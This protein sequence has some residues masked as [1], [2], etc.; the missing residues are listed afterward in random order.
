MT[1]RKKYS[2][3]QIVKHTNI[4]RKII[5]KNKNKCMKELGYKSQFKTLPRKTKKRIMKCVSKKYFG[6]GNY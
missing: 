1:T 4:S 5:D 6:F 2:W 3:K